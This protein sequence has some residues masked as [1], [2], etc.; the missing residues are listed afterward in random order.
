MMSIYK[1]KIQFKQRGSGRYAAVFEQ[2]ERIHEIGQIHRQSTATTQWELPGAASRETV[3]G[4]FCQI[5]EIILH[6][7]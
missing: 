2:I 6:E 7:N 4:F 5:C 3:N 1:W